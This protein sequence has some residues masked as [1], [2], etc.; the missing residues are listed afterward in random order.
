MEAILKEP[1]AYDAENY[2]QSFY[3]R[4]PVDSRFLNC[5]YQKFM[6]QTSPDASTQTFQLARFEAPNVYNISEAIIQEQ[7]SYFSFKLLKTYFKL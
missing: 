5:P 2:A 7:I 6:P 1:I 3:N 4:T